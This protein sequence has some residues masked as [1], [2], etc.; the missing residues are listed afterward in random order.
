MANKQFSDYEIASISAKEEQEISKL[1][2][3]MRNGTN[4]DVVLI[5][6]QPKNKTND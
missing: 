3:T 2:Q 5:A 4:K 1:E 6:Y